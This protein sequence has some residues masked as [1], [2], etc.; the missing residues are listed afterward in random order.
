MGGGCDSVKAI[1]G[2]FST[3]RYS[4]QMGC[5]DV[6]IKGGTPIK[7]TNPIAPASASA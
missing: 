3:A 7:A 5:D 2:K 6:V 4:V 1:S